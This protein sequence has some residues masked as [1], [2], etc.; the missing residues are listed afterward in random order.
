MSGS[1]KVEIATGA[2][3]PLFDGT[4]SRV[5]D[6]FDRDVTQKIADKGVEYLK[7]WPF[8]SERGGGFQANLKTVRRGSAVK[9]PGPT[10]RGVTWAPWLEGNSKR[11]SSTRF[12]GYKLFAKTAKRLDGEARQIAE[13]ELKKYLPRLG[14]G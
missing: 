11:N 3:G 6:E 9:I 7:A 2:Y 8:K 14:G 5:L 13:D 12:G 10:I 1:L 4:A